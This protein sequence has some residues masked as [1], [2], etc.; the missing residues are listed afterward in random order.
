MRRLVPLALVVLAAAGCGGGGGGEPLSLAGAQID[1][2]SGAPDF[3]LV[4]QD[5]RRVTVS[6]QRGHW[7]VITFL[8]THCPDV[9]PL[10]AANLNRAIATPAG[11]RAGLRVLAVSV[12]PA[13]D[14]PA[15]VRR[16]ARDHRLRPAFHYLIGS[17]AQLRR[18]WADYHVAARPGPSDTVAHSSF[19]LLVDP[20]GQLRLLYDA[21]ITTAELAGDLATLEAA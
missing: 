17:R 11:R 21:R 7:L 5:G 15:A 12:D 4:D 19:E 14:T 9:C 1:P 13:R 3:A 20:D 10:I 16:Y 6:G 8:Y 2:P 18:V